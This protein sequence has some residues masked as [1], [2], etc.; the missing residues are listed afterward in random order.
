MALETTDPADQWFK[1]AL[2]AMTLVG[3]P[4]R[5]WNGKAP[6]K[7]ETPYVVY[8]VSDNRLIQFM[9]RQRVGARPTY[10]VKAVDR[11]TGLSS[12]ARI[13]E[14]FDALIQG[15]GGQS[16]D[17]VQIYRWIGV[18]TISYPEIDENIEYYHMGVTYEGF[19]SRS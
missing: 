11:Y 14:E 2:A 16:Y 19:L 4:P 7:P 1:A 3:S 6:Q 9:D 18:S 15:Q 10:T 17:G 8:M 5:V 12:L 13:V